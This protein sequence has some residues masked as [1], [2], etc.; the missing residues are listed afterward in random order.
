MDNPTTEETPVPTT[1]TP[2]SEAPGADPVAPVEVPG[3]ESAPAADPDDHLEGVES[4]L[5]DPVDN[6]PPT[7][8]QD[9]ATGQLFVQTNAGIASYRAVEKAAP[10]VYAEHFAAVKAN[11]GALLEKIHN[12]VQ[13]S[14][15]AIVSDLEALYAK[16]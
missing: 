10:H 11:I 16:L 5:V 4:G 3:R 15:H 12:G 8:L 1:D 2:V 14:E 7:T 9:P 13:V 6:T